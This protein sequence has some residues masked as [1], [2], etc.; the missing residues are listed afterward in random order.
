[1]VLLVPT[2]LAIY[3]PA[4]LLVHAARRVWNYAAR[5]LRRDDRR[6]GEISQRPLPK[7][8]IDYLWGALRGDFG[9]SYRH[10]ERTVS[11]ALPVAFPS[12]CRRCR[13]PAAGG[14]D[15]LPLRPQRCDITPGRLPDHLSVGGGLCY[16]T[17]CP[18]GVVRAGV[19]DLSVFAHQGSFFSSKSVLPVITPL[20]LR[21]P[22][23]ANTGQHA[24]VLGADY[25]HRTSQRWAEWI[26]IVR[27]GLRNALI[28][29]DSGR[30]AA[31]NTIIGSFFVKHF[32]SARHRP[33]L[34]GE[35]SRG[36]IRSL[37]LAPW[38]VLLLL[39]NLVV[40]VS[41]ALLDPRVRYQ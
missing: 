5:P 9:P 12:H 27:Y 14:A 22:V 30:R 4:F 23:R 7:Q 25:L 37:R 1:L 6:P 18:S 26:V 39:S 2:L 35:C 19:L 10:Q 31:G 11:Q 33:L 40:D 28:P 17:L 34:C 16:P 41:Y 21:G 13:Q 3:T 38:P 20:R 15:R 36:T 8:Y 29:L 32:R 24:D